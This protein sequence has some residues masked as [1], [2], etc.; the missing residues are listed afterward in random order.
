MLNNSKNKIFTTLVI[1]LISFSLLISI[2]IFDQL[3]QKKQILKIYE[4][5]LGQLANNLSFP[6]KMKNATAINS[7]TSKSFF[8]LRSNYIKVMSDEVIYAEKGS[9]DICNQNQILM[10][11]ITYSNKKIGQVIVCYQEKSKLFSIRTILLMS[12]S[13]VCIVGVYLA[14]KLVNKSNI[15]PLVEFVNFVDN[16]DIDKLD[17]PPRPKSSSLSLDIG[18]LYSK[19]EEIF[20][21]HKINKEHQLIVEKQ[22]AE[23][24]VS[25]QIAHDIR[26]PLAALDMAIKSMGDDNSEIHGIINSA[27]DR[28]HNLANN[29][30]KNKSIQ[31]VDT[32]EHF[33]VAKVLK[34]IVSE[35]KVEYM[36][37]NDIKIN[38]KIGPGGYD[39]FTNIDQFE[40][41]RIVS[42]L[43]NNSIEA[44]NKD[45]IQIEI[46]LTSHSATSVDLLIIDDGV[47]IKEENLNKIFRKD[48]SIGKQNGNGLGLFHAKEVLKN[49]NGKIYIESTF[50]EGTKVHLV[51]PKIDSP[52][53]FVSEIYIHND[54]KIVVIDDDV[55]IHN[56][57]KNKFQNEFLSFTN[58]IDFTNWY[59][60]KSKDD[61]LFLFDYE[62]SNSKSNGLNTILN[63]GLQEMS[64]LITSHF[65]NKDIQN[66]C[67]QNGIGIIDKSMIPYIPIHNLDRNQ[68]LLKT[69]ILLDDDPL[70]RMVWK[71]Q[72]K[73]NNLPFVE[74]SNK[75]DFYIAI[76]SFDK[77]STIYIDSELGQGIKG[78]EI[79]EDI[80]QMGFQH[81]FLTTGHDKS[82]FGE[83]KGLTDILGKGAPWA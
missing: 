31:K 59:N 33:Q 19:F 55:S 6:L 28:I 9:V 22:K 3:T 77:E 1:S 4:I 49:A 56:V 17:L 81:I 80:A 66:I 52:K 65:D 42:N 64:F 11:D 43:I 76:S 50:G 71:I 25:R 24:R 36:N 63:L 45:K 73:K 57:W 62:F 12:L 41:S 39:S 37:R 60:E 15:R 18:D 83:I 54:F 67:D 46:I 5:T 44:L 32:I 26:S 47:G 21:L 38:F 7:L 30:L 78:E 13:L 53:T 51:L 68:K 79:V 16:I 35:K 8:N 72:A 14:L 48:V 23:Y 10:K 70:V 2:Y 82:H 61:Y 20:K 34:N 75:E 74:F 69:N 27:V 29:L 40:L 58:I